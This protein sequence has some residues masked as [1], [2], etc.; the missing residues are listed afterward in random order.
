MLGWLECFKIFK[1]DYLI[2]FNVQYGTVFI[3][4]V[5]YDGEIKY[6]QTKVQLVLPSGLATLSSVWI[7]GNRSKSLQNIYAPIEKK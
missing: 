3:N 4:W 6:L 5:T 2:T 7:Y 1:I